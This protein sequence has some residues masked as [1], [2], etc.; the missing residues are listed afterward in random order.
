ML[1]KNTKKNYGIISKT[2]HW[3]IA[4]IFLVQFILIFWKRYF[5]PEGSP[6]KSLLIG[7]LH[8][9]IGMIAFVMGL[10]FILWRLI[11]VKPNFPPA[12]SEWEKITANTV[13]GLLYATM[14]I[15]PLSGLIMSVAAGYPPNFFGLFQVP[16][17]IEINK[18]TADTFF[19]IHE[20]TGIAIIFLVALHTLAALKHHF[21]NRDNV[22][23]RML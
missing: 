7:G 22:L 1:T 4:I 23:K 9:P 13:H 15:M 16:Q 21:I 3:G 8:K 19:E 20:L 10:L 11:N 17:F 2:L 12:M 14:I 6:L 5:L 18:Q